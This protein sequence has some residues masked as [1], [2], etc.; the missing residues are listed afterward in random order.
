MDSEVSAIQILFEDSKKGITCLF[1]EGVVR[2]M[3]IGIHEHEIGSMQDVRFDLYVWLEGAETPTSDSIESVLDYE[4]LHAAIERITKGN[5]TGLLET[6]ASR[7]LD[8]VLYPPEVAAASVRLTKLN[9]KGFDGI[10]GCSMS[11]IK[12]GSSQ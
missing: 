5:R 10:F 2:E 4:Y 9:V 6:M 11:R 1:L 3:D 7:L 12:K 8:E